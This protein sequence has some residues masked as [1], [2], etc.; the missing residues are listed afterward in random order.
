MHG[1]LDLLSPRKA[2][3]HRILRYLAS[4][5]F[6]LGAVFPCFHTTGCEA[7]SFTT[8]GYGIFNVC[9]IVGACRTHE[10]PGQT[11]TSLHKSSLGGTEQLY[12]ALPRQGIEPRVFGFEFR[13]SNH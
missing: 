11:Q 3:I 13:V 8:D 10:G 12:L 1:K 2:N 4:F 9:T 5:Q 7:Y 6:F